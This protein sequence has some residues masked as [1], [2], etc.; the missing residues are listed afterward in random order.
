MS[1]G[2]ITKSY[3]RQ[4]I[5]EVGNSTYSAVTKA[6][7]VDY[8]VGDK[9]N[10]AIIND[11]Q[12]QIVSLIPRANLVYRMDH[13][14]SKLIASNVS[15]IIIIIAIKPNFNPN[16]LN[17]CLLFAESANIRPRIMINKSDLAQSAEFIQQI[18]GLY[19][20]QL[21][22]LVT[23]LSAHI[24]CAGLISVLNNEQSLLIGQSGVGKSTITNWLIP[25]ANT[26]VNEITKSENSG[27]HTTTNT[28]LYHINETSAL[29]DCP[30]LQ[31]FGLY[32]LSVDELPSLFPE[33][34]PYLGKCR[35][36]NCQHLNEPGCVI[37]EAYEKL[38]ID[39]VRFQLLQALVRKLNQ[40]NSY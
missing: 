1:T 33:L 38:Q 15:Q 24:D 10:V 23:S 16:F 20:D 25:Q 39:K 9:V 32:H 13:N 28:T 37:T 35:F 12:L 22:Y 30:G 14:R 5:V 31:E 27:R 17:S 26:S 11:K 2:L 21:G 40:K 6:K 4:F 36:R 19:Q 7:K 29:I 34:R 18:T 3:G 8:V